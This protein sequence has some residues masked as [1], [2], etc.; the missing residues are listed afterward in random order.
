MT[1]KPIRAIRRI[2]EFVNFW[3]KDDRFLEHSTG[4]I[5]VGANVGQERR[6]YA[7]YSLNV[8]WIEPIPELFKKLERNIHRYSNQF[9]IRA[10]VTDKDD[11]PYTFNI[12]S[13]EGESS[14]IFP[15]KFHKDIW[16][17]INYVRSLE[18]VSKTLPK[19]IA[20]ADIDIRKYDALVLDTQGSELLVLQGARSL[21]HHFRYILT[22]VADFEAYFGS[23][24]LADLSEFLAKNNFEEVR[25]NR[26]ARHPS[27]G[28]YF[29]V[30]FERR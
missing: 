24:L 25:R 29:K 16:P 27:G 19:A 1:F 30:L 8:L 5:H 9:A 13:N 12:A 6:Q 3:S 4:V 14:S 21:L 17:R 18:L 15:L 23:C 11:H 22:E 7:K 20:D 10:L 2:A 26:M 28:S